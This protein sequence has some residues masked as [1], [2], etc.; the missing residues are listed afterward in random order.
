MMAARWLGER[1]KAPAYH[2]RRCRQ[3]RRD[4]LYPAYGGWAIC[5]DCLFTHEDRPRQWVSGGSRK[6]RHV[7]EKTG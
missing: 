4:F 6:P 3:C 2:S 1:G 5:H 7:A